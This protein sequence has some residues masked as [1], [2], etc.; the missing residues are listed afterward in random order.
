MNTHLLWI[1]RSEFCPDG[2]F[3]L[4]FLRLRKE[5][6]V[7][8]TFWQSTQGNPQVLSGLVTGKRWPDG[9]PVIMYLVTQHTDMS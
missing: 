9:P 2:G 6:C 7:Q 1:R 4:F 3:G 8:G 5:D